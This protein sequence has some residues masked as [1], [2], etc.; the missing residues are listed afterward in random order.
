LTTTN[1]KLQKRILIIYGRNN[2]KSRAIAGPASFENTVF[3]ALRKPLVGNA[4]LH[5]KDNN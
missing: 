5:A 2:K 4:P 1:L 3:H